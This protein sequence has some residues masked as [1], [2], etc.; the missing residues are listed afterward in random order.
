MAGGQ[1]HGAEG[2]D[3]DHL[4][5]D[6][7][8]HGLAGIRLRKRVRTTLPDQSGR[9]FPDLLG[10][11]MER[12]HLSARRLIW[13]N[14]LLRWDGFMARARGVRA[15][16]PHVDAFRACHNLASLEE[17]VALLG[18]PDDP[19]ELWRLRARLTAEERARHDAFRASLGPSAIWGEY[20]GADEP[21]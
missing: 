14:P 21:A 5:G 1:D 16:L 12:L 3:R 4:G 19:A 7:R 13:L 8:E 20:I 15:M 9:R 18:R 6:L 17:L 2:A 10:R 11:E